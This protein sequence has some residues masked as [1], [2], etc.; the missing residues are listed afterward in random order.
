MLFLK[1]DDLSSKQNFCEIKYSKHITARRVYAFHS[2]SVTYPAS[3]VT[4]PQIFLE[5]LYHMHC[6]KYNSIRVTYLLSTYAEKISFSFFLVI[7]EI[8]YLLITLCR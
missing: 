6:F 4:Y 7:N 2:N 1:C 3:V 8:F 5:I